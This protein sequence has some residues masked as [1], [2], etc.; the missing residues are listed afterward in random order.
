MDFYLTSDSS[1]A[2]HS[3]TS[4]KIVKRI[5]TCKKNNIFHTKTIAIR[6]ESSDIRESS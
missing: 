5:R 2:I 1:P 4:A 3:K 6:V